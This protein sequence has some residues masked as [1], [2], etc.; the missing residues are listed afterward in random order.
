MS[1]VKNIIHAIAEDNLGDAMETFKSVMA[2]KLMEKIEDRKVEVQREISEAYPEIFDSKS[3]EEAVDDHTVEISEPV[4]NMDM[5]VAVEPEGG[6]READ[7][8]G[9]ED[10]EVYEEEEPKPDFLDLDKDGDKKE[11]MSQAAADAEEE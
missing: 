3:D 11:P 8:D 4:P 5:D 1:R 9:T 10:E 2:S 6:H 7:Y